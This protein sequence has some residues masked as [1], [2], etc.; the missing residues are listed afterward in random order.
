MENE[1]PSI[2]AVVISV[3]GRKGNEYVITK[4]TTSASRPASIPTSATVTFSL[5]EWSGEHKP[6]SGQLVLLGDI[7]KFTKGWRARQAMPVRA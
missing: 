3:E 5:S 6:K 1:I 2:E 4:L 7:E